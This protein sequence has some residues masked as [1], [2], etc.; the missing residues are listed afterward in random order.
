V[1][2]GVGRGEKYTERN[3]KEYEESKE[4]DR[5][6]ERDNEQGKES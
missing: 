4:G 3:R 5:E 6:P 1:R 2:R